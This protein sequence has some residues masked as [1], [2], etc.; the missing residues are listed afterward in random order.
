VEAAGL[1]PA[2]ADL[3]ARLQSEGLRV[4]MEV[5]DPRGYGPQVDE[6]LYRACREGLRNVEEHAGATAVTVRVHQDGG[7]AILEVQDDGRGMPDPESGRR[8]YDGHVGVQILREIVQDGGGTLS[9]QPSPDHGT[10]LRAE[11]PIP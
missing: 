8:R 2:L 6:L 4:E 7:R 1:G 11:V 5:A 3:A 10:I 9:V